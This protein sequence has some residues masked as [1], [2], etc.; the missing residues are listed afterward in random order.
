MPARGSSATCG[1]R[2]S[3]AFSSVP[4]R[5]PLPGWTTRPTGLSITSST[6][7]SNTTSSGMASGASGVALGSGSISTRTDSPPLT[8]IRVVPQ[9]SS[10]AILRARI[11]FWMRLRENSGS[12]ADKA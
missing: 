2:C 7:S 11:Q 8:F 9:A 3:R 5:L 12:M 1:T 6:G 10:T 4:W